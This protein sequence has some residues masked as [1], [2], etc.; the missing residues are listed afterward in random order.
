MSRRIPHAPRWLFIVALVCA[1]LA[2]HAQAAAEAKF[3]RR[4]AIANDGTIAF[5]YHDDIWVANADG[6][7]PRRLTAHVGNDFGPKFSPD[8]RT[9]AFTSNRNGNND[10]FVMPVAGGEPQQLTWMSGNDE[11][12]G[13]TPDGKE[14]IISTSRGKMQ[15]GSPLYRVALDGT[16]P[17]PLPM[18]MGRAGMI[19]Q[20][21]TMIA[22]N[23]TLPTYWR[24]GYRGN[25]NADIAVMDL[26]SGVIRE[27]T[28]TVLKN[29][30]QNVHDVYP[31]WGADGKIYYA[32]ERDSYF[33]IW[34]I[35]PD[36][37]RPEQVTRH[38]EGVQFP[39]ISPDGKRLIYQNNFVLWTLDVPSGQPKQIPIRLAFDPKETDISI[40]STTNRADGFAPSPDGDYVAVDLHGDIV[41][42]PSEQGVGDMRRV[43]ESAWRDNGQSWSPNGRYLAYVSDESREWE[44][45]IFELASGQ[46]RKLTNQECEKSGLTWAPNGNSLLYQCNNRLYEVDV[47]RTAAPRELAYNQAGGFNNVSYSADQRWLVYTRSNDEQV[48]EVYLY[49]IANKREI[50]VTHNPIPSGDAAGGGGGGGGRGGGVGNPLLTPDGTHV[51]F[52]SNRTGTNQLYVVSLT[53]MTEDPDDPLVR[54]RKAREAAAQGGRGGGAGGRGGRGGGAGGDATADQTVAPLQ[55]RVDENGIDRRARQITRGTAAVGTVFLSPDGRTI[56]YTM[57]GSGAAPAGG[58]GRGAPAA[59]P[60]GEDN[61]AG[62]YA[63][64]LDGQNNRRIAA[65]TFPGLRVTPDRRMIFFQRPAQGGGGGGGRG[66]GRGN[67]DE[68][69]G[70]EI[71]RL[72]LAQPQRTEPVN[73]SFS[74]RVDRR[75]EWQQTLLEAWRVMKYR[76]Y[77]P[78]M[79]GRDWKAILARYEPL[80]KYAGTND[81]V[82]DIANEMIGQLNASHTGVSLPPTRPIPNIAQTRY[83][84]FELDEGAGGRYRVSHIY[85]DGPADKEWL[86]LSDGDY[87]LAIDGQEI[88][89]GDNYWKILTNTLNTYIP[90]KVA[91]TATGENARTVRIAT[92]ASLNNIKYDEWVNN[93]RDQVDKATNGEVAYVHIRAMDQPSLAQFQREIDRYW[94]KKGIIV[95]IRFNGGGN[96]DQELIDILERRPYEYW[97]NR[98]GS[99]IWGRRPRQLIAGPKVM[100]TNGRSASDSEVTP[101]AFKDLGLGRVVG[102]PTNA[103]VI[104][105][106]S[107]SLLLQGGTIR[108]PGSKVMTYSEDAPNHY[109]FNL[110]NY[111][112][113]PDV[114]VKN[115][116]MDNLK[117][118]DR[119]LQEAI[120]EVQRMRNAAKPKVTSN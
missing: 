53:K 96:I 110:E 41:I 93:N 85:R 6:S 38:R 73:F 5:G 31:M 118:I 102:N 92:I 74:V 60:A 75:E 51:V 120:A 95:D 22:F 54:E 24:T 58:R 79:H 67:A 116:A 117:G 100:M 64:N 40:L 49:D 46:K 25:G 68:P 45:W 28:D 8:G 111:G 105:T 98:N 119:E 1:P 91:K 83:L 19:K 82:E 10:V 26:K 34:R 55:I 78:E 107:Y 57:G 97:N 33:N 44:V 88:R 2:A 29:H 12:V 70:L 99:P 13:W 81:D 87:V 16:I 23:R 59:A 11:A 80:L 108:T 113:E 36:G 62:L 115:N 112:V 43:T 72:T 50:N 3:L 77:D 56:Y 18:D 17:R 69:G 86:D 66:R 48:G 35:N 14:V 32:S 15:W 63:V 76:F 101:Q 103:S 7:N 47:T 9:I 109:G 61:S 20:D 21:A 39:S 71:A 89:N 30:R 114:W 90:V 42:V 27:I 106:G 94:N 84:G 65:G 104:A 4:P 37:S 52:T